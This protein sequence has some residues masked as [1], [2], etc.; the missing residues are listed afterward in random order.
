MP[1]GGRKED[2]FYV[3]ERSY[4]PLAE[5][6]LP[7][8][9]QGQDLVAECLGFAPAARVTVVDLGTG[10]GVTAERVLKRYR[11]A[12][13]IGVDLFDEMLEGAR[14]RLGAYSRRVELVRSDNAR[15]LDSLAR[16][17]DGVVS[18]LCI[19]HQDE[20]GKKGLFK[21]IHRSLVRGGR[22]V[23]FD[24]TSFEDR[25]VGN[26]AHRAVL[27]NLAEKVP[28]R[29]F[30][31]KWRHHWERVNTP[32]PADAM[33]RWLKDLGFRAE[34]AYRDGEI[35]VLVAEKS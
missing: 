26:W 9:T 27:R 1:K 19:H 22:F 35:A 7:F 30:Q 16:P 21:R 5:K 15:Y 25:V 12:R 8:Y 18:A 11:R 4:D 29:A 10:T 13:V 24:W 14:S 20:V 34:T 17:V 6:A 32:S 23:L 33:V 31:R 28:D 3:G 2:F